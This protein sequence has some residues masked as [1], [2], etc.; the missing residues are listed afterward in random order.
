[1]MQKKFVFRK[2]I[3]LILIFD[4]RDLTDGI[5][6][7]SLEFPS[8]IPPGI[9]GWRLEYAEHQNVLQL[10]EYHSKE[11]AINVSVAPFCIFLY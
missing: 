10:A 9:F 8:I 6:L 1:M 4:L 7:S 2:L 11:I 3:R 5:N